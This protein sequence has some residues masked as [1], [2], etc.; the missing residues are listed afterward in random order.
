MGEKRPDVK[1]FAAQKFFIWKPRKQ[2]MTY[3]TTDK[4]NKKT[5]VLRAEQIGS[6]MAKA[7]QMVC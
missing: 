5:D 7:G 4:Y 1:I 6:M 2:C 3:Y